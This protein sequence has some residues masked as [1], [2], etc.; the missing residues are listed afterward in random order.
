MSE[1]AAERGEQELFDRE[2]QIQTLLEAYGRCC[3]QATKTREV[4]AIVGHSGGKVR[5][6]NI[7]VNGK[8]CQISFLTIRKFE[9]KLERQL[10][11]NN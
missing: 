5:S 11:Q 9:L 1:M 8:W 10:W 4:V 6:C 7:P 2:S 3:T